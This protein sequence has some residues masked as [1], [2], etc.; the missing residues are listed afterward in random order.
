MTEDQAR[1]VGELLVGLERLAL[2]LGWRFDGERW[3]KPGEGSGGAGGQRSGGA[4]ERRSRGDGG[5]AG[6]ADG[7]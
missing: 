2:D 1:R 7:V 5:L 4:G 6:C 3:V